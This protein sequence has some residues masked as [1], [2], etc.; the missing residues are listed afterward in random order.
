MTRLP[1][2]IRDMERVSMQGLLADY[3][4][5]KSAAGKLIK[6][7]MGPRELAQRV[8]LPATGVGGLTYT[9]GIKQRR[10]R[11]IK[12]VRKRKRFVSSLFPVEKMKGQILALPGASGGTITYE[13][14]G[15]T[16]RVKKLRPGSFFALVDGE[17]TGRFGDSDQMSDD[18]KNF[19]TTGALP[20][21]KNSLT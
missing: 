17:K 10:N 6:E 5:P 11:G 21:S 3:G 4:F 18:I 19:L 12:P 1:K 2:Y 15:K 20:R 14:E 16:L 7:G 8:R 9:H 13:S